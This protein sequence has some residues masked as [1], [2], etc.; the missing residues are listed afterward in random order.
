LALSIQAGDADDL[1]RIEREL[2]L[3]RIVPYPASLHAQH[4]RLAE[5]LGNGLQC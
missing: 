2:D 3:A 1:A 4:R 5:P